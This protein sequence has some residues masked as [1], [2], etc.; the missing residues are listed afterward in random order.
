[1]RFVRILLAGTALASS[2][3]FAVTDSGTQTQSG[4]QP[5][6]AQMPQE[7]QSQD[8]P[9]FSRGIEHSWTG[10]AESEVGSTLREPNG[11]EPSTTLGEFGAPRSE[12]T[13]LASPS[14]TDNANP[15]PPDPTASETYSPPIGLG[16]D[17]YRS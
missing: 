15:V 17:T 14:D 10:M 16:T 8:N 11:A 6:S 5:S 12:P 1:M 3:A 2:A 13:P 9:W 7:Q 4:E